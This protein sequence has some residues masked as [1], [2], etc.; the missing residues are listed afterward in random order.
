MKPEIVFH[1]QASQ[2]LSTLYCILSPVD[3]AIHFML[4]P[5]PTAKPIN[6]P[7]KMQILIFKIMEYLL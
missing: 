5:P 6:N 3:F 2:R 4:S 1:I 7:F